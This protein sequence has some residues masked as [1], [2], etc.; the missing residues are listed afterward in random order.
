MDRILVFLVLSIFYLIPAVILTLQF[1]LFGKKRAEWSKCESCFLFI[2]LLSFIL[3]LLIGNYSKGFS[4]L[5]TE[6]FLSGIAGGLILVPRLLI[7]KEASVKYK[8]PITTISTLVVCL[9]VFLLYYYMPIL[10]DH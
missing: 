5:F 1:I 2:P 8:Y 4:N 7:K 10:G 6:F 3:I 9:I